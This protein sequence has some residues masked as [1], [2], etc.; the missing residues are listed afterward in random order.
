MGLVRTA[1]QGERPA[2]AGFTTA[3]SLT[4]VDRYSILGFGTLTW[5]AVI[6]GSNISGYLILFGQYTLAHKWLGVLLLQFQKADLPCTTRNVSP[7]TYHTTTV[8]CKYTLRASNGG[9]ARQFSCNALTKPSKVYP[10]LSG[11]GL[12]RT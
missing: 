11:S 5:C 3:Y 6:P 10:H 1:V 9:K 7:D 4:G 8:N 2:G 12:R